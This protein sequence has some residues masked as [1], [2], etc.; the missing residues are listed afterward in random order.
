MAEASIPSER[1]KQGLVTR[2][3]VLGEAHVDRALANET[4]F[5][6]PFQQLITEGAWGSVWSREQWSKRERS[7]VT[8]ALLAALGHDEE[9]A[10]HIRATANTGATRDDICEAL[11][12]VAIYAGV[13]A[14]NHAFKIAKATYAEIDAAKPAAEEQK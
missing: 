9:V 4:P 13:P 5:D 7:M 6:Q 10:M 1:Y 3:S 8:I 14:A 2:R 11:M 12:H